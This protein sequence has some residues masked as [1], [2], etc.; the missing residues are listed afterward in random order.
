MDSAA[1]VKGCLM[2][3]IVMPAGVVRFFVC[4]ALALTRRP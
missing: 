4:E 2:E 1:A 3:K